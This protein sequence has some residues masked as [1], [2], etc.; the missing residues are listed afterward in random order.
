V[1]DHIIV[2]KNAGIE[3]LKT[4]KLFDG[5]SCTL[6]QGNAAPPCHAAVNRR[7]DKR[8]RPYF[9]MVGRVAAAMSLL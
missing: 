1:H 2:S 4:L 9:A 3:S 6:R 5:T 8:S 7:R